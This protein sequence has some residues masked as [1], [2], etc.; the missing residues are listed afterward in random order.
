MDMRAF[1]IAARFPARFN[2]YCDE[3]DA[4]MLAGDLIARTQDG[5]YICGECMS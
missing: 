4:P 1:G 5:D 3:C 2:S